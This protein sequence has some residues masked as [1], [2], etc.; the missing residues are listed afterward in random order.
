MELDT[1]EERIRLLL[2]LAHDAGAT[3]A[4]ASLA[5]ERA[6]ALLLK[7]NLDMIEVEANGKDAKVQTIVDEEFTIDYAGNWRLALTN[8][9]AKHNYCRCIGTGGTGCRIIGRSHNVAVTKDMSLWI[10][11][12]VADLSYERWAIE[13][14]GVG[15]GVGEIQER[16]WKDGFAFGIITRLKERLAEQKAH[17]EGLDSNVRA[18]VVD[19][20]KENEAFINEAY[21]ELI[22]T[23]TTFNSQAYGVGVTAADRVSL[24]PSS[25]QV[26]GEGS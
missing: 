20:A 6:H 5:M 10:Q 9:L 22:N 8:V 15:D 18:L 26:R 13:S 4:E 7:H 17:E 25:R 23:R 19:F 12:Q 2:A 16:D 21:G 14:S 24:S 3:E 1:I 11:G